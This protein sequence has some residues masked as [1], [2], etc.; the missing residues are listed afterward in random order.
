MIHIGPGGVLVIDVKAWC[1]PRV[2]GGHLYNGEALEDDA[3]DSLLAI[4]ALVEEVAGP[5]GLAPLQV[6]PV[7]VFAGRQQPHLNLGR[8]QLLG[9]AGL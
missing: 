9:E 3:V 5:L 2:E 8:V 1:E 7:M 4:A 6:V